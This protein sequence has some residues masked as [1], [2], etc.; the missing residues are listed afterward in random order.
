MNK[1]LKE[2]IRTAKKLRGKG[3]IYLN[4]SVALEAEINYQV[5]AT[6]VEVLNIFIYE[7]TYE[8]LKADKEML[9]NELAV[10]CIGEESLIYNF[11][12][13]IKKNIINDFFDIEDPILIAET[14]FFMHDYA[15]MQELYEKARA[16]I[17]EGKF[18]NFIFKG[19][20]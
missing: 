18:D 8:L 15:K 5:L 14:C 3:L 2:V 11:P 17:K 9:L 7:E 16:Q 4:D 6:I 10:S 19:K 13:D 1:I 12:D 20:Q